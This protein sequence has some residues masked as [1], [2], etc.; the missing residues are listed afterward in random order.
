MSQ[1]K[2]YFTVANFVYYVFLL[3]AYSNIIF[4]FNMLN[5]LMLIVM[6]LI[7]FDILSKYAEYSYERVNNLVIA[8]EIFTII[9]TINSTQTSS[10]SLPMILLYILNILSIIHCI[11]AYCKLGSNPKNE[12]INPIYSL[13]KSNFDIEKRR[14]NNKS[15]MYT[16]HEVC[17]ICLEESLTDLYETNCKHIFHTKC[18]NGWL[19]NNLTTFNCPLCRC[20]LSR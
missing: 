2:T 8:N 5:H 20:K 14:K 18:I 11:F 19:V 12:K 3:F 4:E 17:S 9:L 16:Q 7:Q 15:F 1:I 13:L 6:F 10:I